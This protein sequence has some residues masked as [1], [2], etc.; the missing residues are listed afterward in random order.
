MLKLNLLKPSKKSSASGLE[1][2]VFLWIFIAG[3]IFVSVIGVLLWLSN[4]SYLLFLTLMPLFIGLWLYGSFHVKNLL[5]RH[6][7]SLANII[8]SLRLGDYNMRIAPSRHESAWAD[9]YR[10]LN[11]LAEQHQQQRLHDVESNILLD[12]LLGEFDVP[13]FVF[14]STKILKNCN[15]KASQLLLKPKSQLINLNSQQLQLE[16]LL[17]SDSGTVIEHWFPSQGGRWELRKNTF[18]QDGQRYFLVLA[19]DLSR[20]LREEEQHAWTRLIRV[21]GHELN[22]SLASLISVSQTLLTRL[23]HDKDEKWYRHFEKALNLIHERSG[24]LLR[25]TDA[26][27]QLAKLPAPSLKQV[28]LLSTFNKLSELVEGNFAMTNTQPLSVHADPDQLE[29]VLINLMKNAVEAS[30][31]EETVTIK[32]R[33]YQ[34]GVRVQ[35]IDSGVGLPSSDNLFVPFYTTKKDGNG[36]GLFLCRQI[37]EAHNG[38]LQLLNRTEGTGCIAQLWLPYLDI[39]NEKDDR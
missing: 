17:Q 28:E 33:E 38:S 13:V 19:N 8:E 25:F 29:Q 14:N 22:N 32:W 26:Y 31:T 27:T 23:H 30:S 16:K 37:A 2:S 39:K 36:I 4:V 21:L 9:V 5:T 6:F 12:K 10:E 15:D 3:F 1:H 7:F 35:I 24:S 20:A 34:Q 11:L 18:I